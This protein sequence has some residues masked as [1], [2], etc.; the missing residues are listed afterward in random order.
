MLII[1][2]YTIITD[3]VVKTLIIMKAL[4][5]YL[6]HVI[7]LLIVESAQIRQSVRPVLMVKIYIII[8]VLP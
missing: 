1:F 2:L 3:V 5:V 8:L 6:K 4:P 7:L